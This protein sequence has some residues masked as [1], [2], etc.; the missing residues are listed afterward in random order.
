MSS[1]IKPGLIKIRS[2]IDDTPD[3]RAWLVYSVSNGSGTLLYL[4]PAGAA[5]V[6]WKQQSSVGWGILSPDGKRLAVLAQSNSGNM[7]LLE[8]LGKKS[9]F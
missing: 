6:V 4:D 1:A 7:W 5:H 2:S 9:Y 3:G 8:G